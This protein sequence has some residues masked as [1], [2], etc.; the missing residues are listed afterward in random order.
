MWEWELAIR[1]DPDREL[2]KDVETCIL[3]GVWVM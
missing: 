3:I 1:A 2:S